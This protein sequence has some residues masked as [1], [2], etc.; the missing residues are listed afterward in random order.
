LTSLP[1]TTPG[2]VPPGDGMATDCQ[3]RSPPTATAS[4]RSAEGSVRRAA[5]VMGSKI[6]VADV[7]SGERSSIAPTIPDDGSWSERTTSAAVDCTCATVEAFAESRS[8]WA[9]WTR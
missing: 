6:D 9:L 5:F 7:S 8:V 4:R 3:L 1:I 2:A